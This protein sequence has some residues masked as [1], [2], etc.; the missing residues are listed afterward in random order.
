MTLQIYGSHRD[1][2]ASFDDDGAHYGFTLAPCP[3][4]GSGK[5][6]I[7][8]THSAS[9]W[10]ECLD[11]DAI[12]HGAHYGTSQRTKASCATAHEKAMRSAVFKWNRRA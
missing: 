3:F 8:N 4:C 10:V 6:A 9:Y 2:S 5:L 11:C 12:A 1:Y 7:M